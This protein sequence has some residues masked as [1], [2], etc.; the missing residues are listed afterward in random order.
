[1]DRESIKFEVNLHL[2]GLVAQTNN[3]PLVH[4]LLKEQSPSS[5]EIDNLISLTG[6]EVFK[7]HGVEF[8]E[9]IEEI[10][11]RRVQD[12]S[13]MI[14]PNGVGF[15]KIKAPK[16]VNPPVPVK[17]TDNVVRVRH[18]EA[19]TLIWVND[20]NVFLDIP[21]NIA[22][23]QQMIIARAA[24]ATQV[25]SRYKVVFK[26]RGQASPYRSVPKGS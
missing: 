12:G 9:E 23:G 6:S 26:L 14:D 8:Y 1:V 21:N 7:V 17:F 15:K 20:D 19:K 3:G 18:Y 2:L 22:F 10:S 16:P 13:G 11:R 4:T 25:F 24:N 5:Y